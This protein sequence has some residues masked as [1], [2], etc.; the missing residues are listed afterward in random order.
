M[1]DLDFVHRYQPAA[2]PDAPVFLLLHGT[3]GDESDL[4]PLAHELD[5]TA[6]ILS[7]R[8]R[9]L[10]NGRPRFFRRFAEGV[11][12]EADIIARAHEL[13][14]FIR[15]AAERYQ[16][17]RRRLIAV[18]YSNGANIAAAMMFLRPEILAGAIL[19]RA[20]V[21]LSKTPVV[22]LQRRQILLSAGREDPIVPLENVQR[23]AAHFRNADAEVVLEV[24][25]TGHGLVAADI[26]A[27]S[28]WLPQRNWSG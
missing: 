18:G 21:V 13:A 24:Q 27:A 3:G 2:D 4:L 23:L 6:G 22:D 17:D 20:M 7:P 14:D 16:F 11:F 1:S 26:A 19:F 12:D 25:P 8:G 28:A 9:V 5:P 15:Q 10:E